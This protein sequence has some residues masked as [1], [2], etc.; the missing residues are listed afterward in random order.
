MH[1]LHS[2]ADRH[3]V[4]STLAL[5][6]SF[7]FFFDK[8]GSADVP[9]LIALDYSHS[10]ISVTTGPATHWPLESGAFVFQPVW[11]EAKMGRWGLG[12]RG[13]WKELP[14]LWVGR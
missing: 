7:F 14:A 12:I 9:L 3:P 11:T 13:W 8:H 1:C 6:T 4:D 5:F 2:P 10:F